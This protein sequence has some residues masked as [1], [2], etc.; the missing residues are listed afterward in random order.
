MLSP[1]TTA[2]SDRPRIV[3]VQ[4]WLEEVKR[5]IPSN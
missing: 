4:N 2:V 5:L 3:V 1:S